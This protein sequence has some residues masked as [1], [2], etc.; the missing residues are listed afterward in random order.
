MQITMSRNGTKKCFLEK[1]STIKN[2]KKIVREIAICKQNRF[3]KSSFLT[4][5]IKSALLWYTHTLI[6]RMHLL[7]HFKTDI[8][9]LP[10]Y[11]IIHTCHSKIIQF[12]KIHKRE[13]KR[14]WFSEQ[15]KS[16]SSSSD[17]DDDDTSQSS[18]S[19][20]GETSSETESENNKKRGHSTSPYRTYSPDYYRRSTERTYYSPNY[21]PWSRSSSSESN[22]SKLSDRLINSKSNAKLLKKSVSNCKTKYTHK[23]IR[24]THCHTHTYPSAKK[25]VT[26]VPN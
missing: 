6:F 7:W 4:N 22:H 18:D 24:N 2:Q 17:D 8:T 10:I 1:N 23:N 15:S 20:S 13:V 16:S 12:K 25:K 21:C 26:K 9:R 14:K 11:F 3:F 19:S 5:W